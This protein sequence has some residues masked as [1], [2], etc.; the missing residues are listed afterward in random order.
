MTQIT[1]PAPRSTDILI[2]LHKHLQPLFG[3]A[4]DHDRLF[5]AIGQARFVLLG[6]ASHG[7]REF[8]RE[9]IDITRRLILEQRLDA[10][11]VE[12]D[13]PDA[14]RVNCYVQGRSDD[15]SAQAALSGFQRFP[16]WMWRNTEVLDFVQ[17][18]R[19]HNLQRPATERVG[20]YGLDLYSLFRSMAQ[21]LAYLE[22]TDPAASRRARA[23]Y[24]CFDH[25]REDSQAYG[26]ATGYGL[27]RSCEDEVVAQ[28]RD[29]CLQSPSAAGGALAADDLFNA[30]H[31]ARLVRNAEAYYRSMF[32]GRVSSWNL[33]DSHMLQT[34][35]ALDGHLQRALGRPPR[36]AVWAH[37]SHLGDALATEM[38]ERGEWNLGQLMRQRYGSQVFNVG[39]STYQG[40]VTAAQDWDGPAS[41]KRVRPG[42]PSSWEALLHQCE[43]ERFLLVFRGNHAL[44]HLSRGRRLQRAIGVI[45]RPQTERLSH[46]FH[47]QL[48][49]QFDALLHFDDTLALEPL[50]TGPAW[51][52]GEIPE[53]YPSGM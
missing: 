50:D 46:Y 4:S 41:R 38:G 2:G 47:T 11:A 23:R 40:W 52:S 37:N 34:V 20:F 5:D 22:R 31:N 18:L 19:E 9:R 36:M 27:A 32:R 26:Y 1:A 39:M 6:E 21:V 44:S 45:Y 17:W 7:T 3:H 14:W 49:Q 35:E 12:A 28:L 29:M 8:Y 33:R 53:T 42:L 25:V 30:Q 43:T 10:V 48:P 16:A 15:S 24:A 51:V 13:W